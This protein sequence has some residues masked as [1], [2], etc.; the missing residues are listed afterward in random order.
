[1][2]IVLTPTKA[3][4]PDAALPSVPVPKWAAM[5]Q[6]AE[7]ALFFRPRPRSPAEFIERF[8]AS[9]RS[10]RLLLP[11]RRLLTLVKVYTGLLPPTSEDWKWLV[12]TLNEAKALQRADSHG[13]AWDDLPLSQGVFHCLLALAQAHTG[14]WD[15]ARRSAA[16][17][18]HTATKDGLKLSSEH[19]YV[20]VLPLGVSPTMQAYVKLVRDARRSKDI[21]DVVLRSNATLRKMLMGLDSTRPD[22]EPVRQLRLALHSALGDISDPFAWFTEVLA[23]RKSAPHEVYMTANTFLAAF[24]ASDSRTVGEAY[25]LWRN[26]TQ[27]FNSTFVPAHLAAELAQR[28]SEHGS[29]AA[30]REVFVRMREKWATLPHSALSV[31]LRICANEGKTAEAQEVWAD[32]TGRYGPTREDKVAFALAYAMNGD[33]ESAEEMIKHLL[34]PRAFESADALGVMQRAY[35]AAGDLNTAHEYLRRAARI[36]PRI[37]DFQNLLSRYASQGEAEKA[38][39]LFDEMIR[40]GLRPT[41]HTYTSL[42]SNFARTGDY[43]NADLTFEGMV[44]AGFTPD[45][46]A[47]SAVINAALEAGEWDH[48]A[49][50]CD[51]VPAN[52]LHNGALASIIMKAFVLINAPLEVT[53]RQFRE[54]PVPNERMWALAMQAAAD[55]EDM[56]MV[57]ALFEEMD[58]RSKLDFLSPAPNV[59]VFSILL[60]TFIRAGD[61]PMAKATYDAMISRKI[62]PSSVTYGLLTSSFADAP[63][64]SSFEQGDNFARTVFEHLENTAHADAESEGRAAADIFRP[65][66][67]A[68]GRNGDMALARRYFDL[69]K[70]KGGN[71][72]YMT[73][74]LM[75]AYRRAGQTKMVYRLWC[76]TFRD[77]L[78]A[79][80]RHKS[81]NTLD[82]VRSRNNL[83]CVPLSVTLQAF[84]DVG[85]HDRIQ[86]L[87]RDVRQSGFGFDAQ[88]YNHLVRGLAVTGDVESAFRVV[89]RVLIPRW[90][91]VR[92]R[93]YRAMREQ[94]KLQVVDVEANEDAD[95][96]DLGAAEIEAQ[97]SALPDAYVEPVSPFDRRPRPSFGLRADYNPDAVPAPAQPQPAIEV[98]S[99]LPYL[100]SSDVATPPRRPNRRLEIQSYTPDE[101]KDGYEGEGEGEGE[102]MRGA[103]LSLLRYWRPTDVLWRPSRKTVAILEQSYRQIE[104]QR[105]YRAWVG[106]GGSEDE[107]ADEQAPVTLPEFDN[108]V[109]KNPDSS[110]N[111]RSP[112]MMLAR[113]GRYYS[114]TVGLVMLYRRKQEHLKRMLERSDM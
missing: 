54:V 79:I 7:F 57:Q 31:E 109:V 93:Q 88:N 66:L 39:R 21:A 28:L 3:P 10:P 51:R 18:L 63:G 43:L 77:A 96:P 16:F 27:E 48:A 29:P 97:A 114:R 15:A 30:A 110:V 98:A 1:M 33:V 104:D 106:L 61:R 4:K 11:Y 8:E 75:D 58:A 2:P 20:D 59:Y 76:K 107:Q 112:G 83:I 34:G 56:I 40:F 102:D 74:V 22:P 69:V 95:E 62:I 71:S 24:L 38:V 26:I 14:D 65:L 87:W 36:K 85:R 101:F 94:A 73:T 113:L 23:S 72:I 99:A 82:A 35:A 41:T 17:G 111:K 32:L 53:L 42:I 86:K 84:T 52:L 70:D 105:A 68:A 60:S 67:T 90:D 78:R 55:H 12:D 91:E 92:A 44:Q 45:A 19:S 100:T 37:I 5:P 81:S 9:G 89:E 25:S 49:M 13:P 80:P 47:Y 46:V 64:T 50:W 103:D 108:A 6:K